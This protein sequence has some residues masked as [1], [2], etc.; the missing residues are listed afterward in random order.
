[1]GMNVEVSSS[2]NQRHEVED[3]NQGYL[4]RF[5]ACFHGFYECLTISKRKIMRKLCICELPK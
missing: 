3:D 1:V 2:K 4:Y 5:P